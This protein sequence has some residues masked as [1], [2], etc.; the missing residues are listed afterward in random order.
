[1]IEDQHRG[2]AAG[3]E[4]AR[5]ELPPIPDRL[6]FNPGG[7]A[8]L[9]AE[10]NSREAIFDAMRRREA[11][12]TTGPRIT[13]RFFGGWD[14]PEDLCDRPDFLAT[15]Y[16]RGVPMGGDLPPRPAAAGAN[17]AGVAGAAEDA[18]VAAARAPSPA[19]RFAVMALRDAGGGGS[20]ST[21]LQ[22]LQIV[23]GWVENGQGRERVYEVA[24]D[25][26]G[27]AGVDLRTCTPR[28]RGFDEL[29]TVWQAPDFDPSAPAFYYARAVENPSC[30]WNTYVCNAH[31]VD[32]ASPDTVPR[33]LRP[34]CD[35]AW[36]KTIQERAW[37][38]PIW[39]SP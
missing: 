9:W 15:G 4:D 20:P 18:S 5:F 27:A 7:L 21:A 10:E 14:Y 17:A 8:V 22:R 33:E 26:G 24:G 31:G 32:C 11:Y 6:D 2:H 38:S 36:P 25:P 3:S 29:C 19:P 1:M 16:A 37:S 12:G 34:C 39:F 13:L 28:G 23:K 35:P 30:R